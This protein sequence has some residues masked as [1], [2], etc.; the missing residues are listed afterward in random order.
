MHELDAFA[1][2]YDFPLDEFQVA[3][4]RALLEGRSVLVAAPTGAGKTVVGEFAVW[5]ALHR[6]GK[7]FYT[8]PIKALSN[9]KFA[10]LSRRHGADTVGLLTGDNAVNGDAPIVV[11]TTEVLR[12]MLYEASP[13]LVGLHAVVLDEVHYLADRE[14]GAVWEEVIVQLASSV[15]L[16]CLSATVSNAEE[17][18]AW[19]AE[20]RDGCDVVITDERPVPLEHSY[21]VND[22]LYP[23]FTTGRKQAGRRSDRER[24]Q[25]AREGRAG[26]PNPEVLMLERRARQRGRVSRRGRHQTTGVR[27]RPPRRSRVVTELARRRWLPAIVFV[28]SRDGCDAAVSQ[29]VA[30]G[31]SLTTVA[32]Q[33]R[34]RRLVDERTADLP[35]E[36]LEALGYGAWAEG[37]E[38]GLAAHHAGMV[39]VFKETVEELFVRGLVKVCF[40][41]ETL[42]LGI[43]MPARTVVIE[44]LEKWTGQAH[45][46][47]TPGQFTQLTGRA[48]RRGLDSVGHAVVLYQRDVDFSTVASLVS[49]RTEPLRSSFAPSYNMAVNLLR[50]RDRAAAE[51][52]LARSFAQFRADRTVA[53]D[54][55]RAA[56]NREA[57]A[58]YAARL[59]SERGDFAEYWALRRE[60]SQLEAASAKERKQRRAS[61]VEQ[62]L[63]GLGE[64]DVVVL[65]DGGAGRDLAVIVSR[66]S[67]RSGTP[68]ASAV[69]SDRRLVR[70]GPRELDRPPVK[71]GALR[72]PRKGGPRQHAYRK[73]LA[74]Q[75]RAFDVGDVEVAPPPRVD[76]DVAERIRRLRAAVRAHPVHDDPARPELETWAHRYD[77]LLAETERLEAAIRR[78]TGSLVRQFDRIVGVLLDLGYLAG[79]RDDPSPT[80]A[81]LL[82]A[83]LYADTD[84]VLAESLRR[85]LL[86]DLDPADLAAVVSAF[87]FETRAKEPPALVFPSTVVRERLDAVT[88]VWR[89]VVAREEA[90]GLPLTRAPDPGFCDV[91]HRWATGADLDDALGGDELS[92]GDF[93]R[94]VKQVAD[95]LGQIRDVAEEGPVAQAAQRARRELVR[96]VVA[97][98]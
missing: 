21:F 97:Y 44:R 87:V 79:D 37:L 31:V 78:R 85:G 95:V 49:R 17:F 96:G 11:M 74:D 2:G 86:D 23:V 77:D 29:L 12:N 93:V 16:A 1:A 51:R 20:V 61:A 64:G 30:E 94:T 41:T 68:L 90:A 26:V 38:R 34:I 66:G 57:L 3:A 59:R 36:D 56:A 5:H 6:G 40:A 48:G 35:A 65:G 18:G 82:L 91:C 84:L 81:G 54:E 25:A 22:R 13:A 70:L 52:L 76:P 75:L 19:L 43:N 4:I 32:E 45:E 58:G 89:E 10:D 67:T 92:A 69:T 46:L 73:L 83:G 33:H 55:A 63:A 60:L 8:T 14:R 53:A 62:A 7:C 50:R 28:F 47:L 98:T 71:V 42:A 39:P 9:Q 15:Q 27:L 80:E 24:E 88:A 72:L